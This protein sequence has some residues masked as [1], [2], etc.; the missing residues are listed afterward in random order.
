[1]IATP[2]VCRTW[3]VAC[4]CIALTIVSVSPAPAAGRSEIDL[5]GIGWRLWH[6]TAASWQDDRLQFPA[7]PLSEL[8]VNLPT[9]GW[10]QLLGSAAAIAV[11]VPG[12]VEEYL[13]QSPGPDGDLTGV[14]WWIR[15]IDIPTADTP[16]RILLRFESVRERAEVFINR[17]LVAYDIVGSSPFEADI[18][19]FTRPGER[20]E[21]A[22]RV[23][24][25]G[26]NF[27]WR[28][29]RAMRWGEHR[30]PLS[31]GFGGI[32]GRVRLVVC[33]PIHI[34]DVYVQN[35]PAITRA[36]ALVT[37]RNSTGVPVRRALDLRVVAKGA[38]GP[39]VFS[40][41]VRDVALPPGD[42]VVSVAIDAPAARL[43]HVDHPD[44]HVCEVVLRDGSV[45]TDADR[46]TFGFRW[47]AMDGVGQDAVLRLNGRR[48]VLRSAISWGF[49]PVNGNHPT[50]ELAER[51][52][53][54][55]KE[56]G[57][58]ML[59]FHRAIGNPIV[60][61][62]ADELGLLYFEEPG[63]YKSAD[64]DPFGHAVVREKWLRMVR[65][66]RSHPS[67][68]I[69]NLI[70]EWNSRNP[71]PEP[72]E[73]ERH[74][75][76]LQAAR[77][78]D[79]SR[80]IMHT[81]AWARA[82]D[83]EE[84]AKLHYRPFDDRPYWNG[85][86]DVHHAGGPATWTEDLYRGP[87]EF[88]LHTDNTRE[89]V[90]WGEEG[91]LSSP[92]RLERIAQDLAGAPRL[93]WDGAAYLDWFRQFDEFLTRKDL[94]S[95]FP[96]VDALTAAMGA[97]SL[98][99]QGRRIENV[100]MANVTDGYTV[101]GWE[102]E[103]IE[104]YSGI[105]DCF[106][107]P[108]GDPAILAYYNQPCFVAVKA[109]N[110]VIQ[111]PG[112]VVVDFF[113]VNEVDL[114]GSHTLRAALRD[115][116]GREV[117]RF[118]RAVVLA[119]GDTF[120]EFLAEAVELPVEAGCVGALRIE[121]VIVDA[122][123][124][125]RAR[126]RDDLWSVDWR[127]D[128]IT[129]TGAVWEDDGRVADFL[130]RE[131]GADVEAYSENLG[132]LDWLVVARPPLEGEAVLI[133]A[134]QFLAPLGGGAGLQATF[135]RDDQFSQPVHRRT[136]AGLAYA[137]EEGAAPDPALSVMTHYSVRW[138]GSLVPLRDGPHILTVRA[139]GAVRLRL[140]TET[141][142]DTS[143]PGDGQRTSRATVDLK[144]GIALPL[145][146]EFRQGTGD[147]RCE[148]AWSPPGDAGTV[149]PGILER[150]RR[151]GT[152]LVILDHA[153]FWM[154]LLAAAPESTLRYD[155]SFKVG[156]TWLGGLH[157]AKEHALLRGL[158]VNTALDWPYQA[159][160]RNGDQRIGLKL[161]GEELVAGCWHSYPMH[162]GTALGVVAYG[163]GSVIVS[164][165]DIVDNLASPE[166]PAQVARKLL[167]NFIAAPR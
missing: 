94:R 103:L 81:S 110:T 145:S 158:P 118:E 97:V 82:K 22:V 143:I 83:T 126:G 150:V 137:V 125:E 121:A 18:T 132:R 65:R 35:T 146:L 76:D 27:D 14:S 36:N 95:A 112:G 39:S 140:G 85:W 134:S 54:V 117:S 98:H 165:L 47:F 96:S 152:R 19:A 11:S 93:G 108:K 151:D 122:A 106:R 161:E 52:V 67:L 73:V 155:G 75:A 114:R 115:A 153:A 44:L 9:G 28:D 38:P 58:N 107:H 66:D 6:D 5:S 34:E 144:A 78:I 147:A 1:M 148:L 62:L 124:V 25:P 61:D 51:Q 79:P 37:V 17:R 133:P 68:V 8:P 30:L 131:K 123:G 101:N 13:Q 167:G 45:E 149:P 142:F 139:S 40:T 154:P 59:N 99:H 48:I 74:R 157:F 130:R 163:R 116:A 111:P 7:P 69:F 84:P 53:R 141:I 20:C 4:V 32:T 63:A 127:S 119:G 33:D 100:R 49:W 86:Y 87:Q 42:T 15:P 88:H 135:F 128:A 2:V 91:A 90:F 10:D 71:H 43:W 138:T 120:G 55:A 159:V 105:V 60:L 109:R 70:N 166:G 89:I 16:R 23:T 21:L 104:N 113:I 80:L 26:G 46:R 24:D 64:S 41:R 92:P 164:T 77:E 3:R 129:G 50:P 57:L 31:H 162:L 136:D 29:S 12:T 160:V 56:L 102:S 72:V 156:R